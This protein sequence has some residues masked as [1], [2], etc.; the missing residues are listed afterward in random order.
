[1][2]IFCDYAQVTLEAGKGGN[3]LIAFRREKFIPF[4]GPDGGNGGKGGDIYFQASDN[5]NTLSDFRTYK[6]FK[7]TDGEPGGGNNCTG[8]HGTDLILP[9]AVGTVVKENGVV[10]ADLSQPGQLVLIAAGGR[11]GYGNQHFVSA[12][13][14]APEFAELGEDGDKK[15]LE[16]ELKLIADVGLVGYPSVGKSTLISVISNAKPKIADY[17]F[18][19]LI[20]NLGVVRFDDYDFV[21]ADIPG[22]I[23][24]AH[25]GKGLGVEFLKHIQRTRVILHILDVQSN[26]IVADYHAIRKELELFDP[27]ILEKPE[28]IVLNKIDT[29]DEDTVSLLIDTLCEAKVAKKKKDVY[30]ISSVAHQGLN[31]L[32]YKVGTMLSTLP[33]VR[34]DDM[35][36][37]VDPTLIPVLRPHLENAAKSFFIDR[38]EPDVIQIKGQ[39]IEQIANMTDVTNQEGLARLYDIFHKLGIMKLLRREKEAHN[40]LVH[41]GKQKLPFKDIPLY[42]NKKG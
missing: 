16:L 20:P 18:T 23:E 6:F 25:A 10:V 41:I 22:L 38:L 40:A 8:A 28:I 29:I 9:V 13:R 31:P 42:R 26:D 21:V 39:R 7:A 14:Q 12:I 35:P 19:T 5:V 36:V 15:E 2:A 37:E 27:A 34:F 24:G 11:G 3:G 33:K 17:P 32:L 4:G 30:A 1:M